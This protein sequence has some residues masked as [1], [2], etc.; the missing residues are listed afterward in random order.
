MEATLV[1]H[2]P[3]P[4]SLDGNDLRDDAQIILSDQTGCPIAEAFLQ[5]RGGECEA[6]ARLIAAAPT[7]RSALTEALPLLVIYLRGDLNG[8]CKIDANGEPDRS[9]LDR[10]FLPLVVACEAAIKSANHALALADRG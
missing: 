1:Q 8:G 3:G 10:D 2:S 9:T 4:W 5:A 7:M 6:N